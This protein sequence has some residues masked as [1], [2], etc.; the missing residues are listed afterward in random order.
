MPIQTPQNTPAY[1]AAILAAMTATG[2]TNLA[3]GAKARAFCDAVGDQLGQLETR[4]YINLSQTLLPYATGNAL[5]MIGEIFGVPRLA[6][7]DATV[8]STDNNF[9]FYVR[10]GTFGDINNGQD[11]SIPANVQIYAQGSTVPAYATQAITLPA[12]QSSVSFTALSLLT[13]SAG[14]ASAGVFKQHN[15]TGYAQSQFGSLLVR[16]NFGI[17]GG[18]DDEDDDSYRYRIHLKLQARNGVNES[19]IR[20]VLLSLP[21]V[22]DVVFSPLAGSFWVYLFGVSPQVPASLLQLAQQAV[23]ET[24]TFP[25]QGTV[26]TPD[27]VGI[28]LSTTLS[29]AR[30][31]SPSDSSV[32]VANAQNAAANFLNNLSTNQ[33]L[34]INAVAAAIRN[35]DPRI[36]DVGG[37]D[38]EI[39]NIF[40][41]RSRSDGTR[42]SRFLVNNYTPA[43]GERILVETSIANP[44]SIAVSTS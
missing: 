2:I 31:T 1:Q 10:T 22:Q 43:L 33:D 3:P 29:L 30:G 44:I 32:I 37:P 35:S 42:Y 23:N 36:T 9:Q 41:W 15:F 38:R 17:V 6:R 28:S 4:Q 20:L 26:L 13:G 19:A 5:D 7:Q 40:I 16:N 14:N 25:I 18:R 39:Q 27:L 34:I 12:G 24:V 8:Y 11:I 21:G